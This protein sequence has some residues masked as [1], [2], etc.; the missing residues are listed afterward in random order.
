MS[1]KTWVVTCSFAAMV[2]VAVG[3]VHAGLSR[4]EVSAPSTSSGTSLP[5]PHEQWASETAPL[6]G[7]L[8]SERTSPETS[9]ATR[10]KAAAKAPKSA[11]AK[12]KIGNKPAKPSAASSAGGVK[13]RK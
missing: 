12:S 5:A 3:A 4:D 2:G 7:G 11:T 10:S 1:W 6:R 8:A 13:K 9:R